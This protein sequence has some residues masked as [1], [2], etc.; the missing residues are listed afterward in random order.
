MTPEQTPK[1]KIDADLAL[2]HDYVADLI[3]TGW[4]IP[5]M[6]SRMDPEG[7][8][9]CCVL[10][11]VEFIAGLHDPGVNPFLLIDG[12]GMPFYVAGTQRPISSCPLAV[13]ND[14][15]D[16]PLVVKILRKRAVVFQNRSKGL[17][18]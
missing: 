17:P 18:E 12:T 7:N 5:G 6:G 4:L 3:E 2:A 13:A 15:K 14:A 8:S 9:P 1:Q 16:W 11:W 10:G